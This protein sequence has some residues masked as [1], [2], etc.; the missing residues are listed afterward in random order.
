MM[1]LLIRIPEVLRP[2]IFSET[3]DYVYLF[4]PLTQVHGVDARGAGFHHAILAYSFFLSCLSST[5][6]VLSAWRSASQSDI[7]R[8][9]E[10]M[11]ER[12]KRVPIPPP[13]L[14]EMIYGVHFSILSFLRVIITRLSNTQLVTS[15][16]YRFL[17]MNMSPDS[18]IWFIDVL[19][20][21][22]HKDLDLFYAQ[23]TPTVYQ[24]LNRLFVHTAY[25]PYISSFF[26]SLL[27]AEMKNY[28][29]N[30][31]TLALCAR[32]LYLFLPKGLEW[33]DTEGLSQLR[34][35]VIPASKALKPIAALV[36]K[37]TAVDAAMTRLAVSREECSLNIMKVVVALR[38]SPDVLVQALEN[39]AAF[40]A[41]AGCFE[42]EM[43]TLLV[44]IAVLLEFLT[45]LRRVPRVFRTRHAGA[46][47]A[48]LC[49]ATDLARYQHERC[50]E[51]P[52]FCDPET[53]NFSALVDRLFEIP[54]IVRRERRGFEYA[55]RLVD[56]AW[57]LLEGV[58]CRS[59]LAE[60]AAAL[61]DIARIRDAIPPDQ[62]L[63]YGH[64]FKVTFYG[65]AFG[66]N[67]GRTFVFRENGLT[68][69]YEL[70]SRLV[71]EYAQILGRPVELIKESGD[72]NPDP[73][74]P[75]IQITFVEP[76]VDGEAAHSEFDL[77]HNIAAFY[78]DTPFTKGGRAQG[79][80][81]E[82]WIRRTVLTLDVLMPTVTKIAFCKASAITKE[83][84]EPI[85]V[86]YMQLKGRVAVL[87]Q[88]LN[89][90][91][92][93]KVQQLLHGSL[94]VQVNEGP[95]KIA[96]VF[97][98]AGQER[99]YVR[100]L[101]QTFRDFLTVIEEAL[102]FH[103]NWV[104]TQPEFR[105]LQDELEAGFTSLGERLAEYLPPQS[106]SV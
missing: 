55:L 81:G 50:P 61:A 89:E 103:R 69:L 100:M 28:N 57:P 21:V 6:A 75:S 27:T 46:A 48:Y 56:I 70:S 51:L 76:Q 3:F 66:E 24:F 52:G 72:C 7:F 77:K 2:L 44:I 25:S 98:S 101:R 84:Y 92:Y 83:E 15:V 42:E 11:L 78:F 106:S 104:V 40:H 38:V 64:Y 10:F 37:I 19:E 14:K 13:G 30:E 4:T 97:L 91:D 63:L 87:R 62:D 105:R 29:S 18:Y 96:E 65:A 33:R 90:R 67:T 95:G 17:R 41:G 16:L 1:R 23:T 99:R 68:H 43:Q 82:Q 5:P 32:A 60:F 59:K 85:R 86:A 20:R 79:S 35:I 71:A 39:L 54:A 94:L 53:F 34:R 8:S 12:A 26:S 93:G 31:R 58:R 22:I 9:I 73:E 102:V 74:V 47:L 80:L 88:A 45:V 36:T 49:T